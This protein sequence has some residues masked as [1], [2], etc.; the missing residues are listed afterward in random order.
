MRRFSTGA[1]AAVFGTVVVLV[2]SPVF[3]QSAGP[4]AAAGPTM[5]STRTDSLAVAR[6]YI[7]WFFTGQMRTQAPPVDP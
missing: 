2:Q 7:A 1:M 3:A 4:P 6:K 5:A